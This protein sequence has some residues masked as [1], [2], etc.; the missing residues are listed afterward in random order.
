MPMQSR[1]ILPPCERPAVGVVGT[2]QKFAVRR[3]YCVGQNYAEHSRE[4]G[5]DPDKE[6]P[7][8]FS[9]PADAIVADGGDVPFPSQ[10]RDLHHEIELVVAIAKGGRDIAIEAAADHI[11]GYAVGIDL[12]RRDIQAEAKKKGRPWDMAK[13]FDAS[14]PI[15]PIAPVQVMG[16]PQQGRIW[17]SV[18]DYVQQD[19]DLNQM[20]WSPGHIISILSRYVALCPGDLVFTGTP[21]GVGPLERGDRVTAGIEG[22]GELEIRII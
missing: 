9:K 5:G 1:F 18:N 19:G 7:F 14:A 11:F 13:G 21:A 6:E 2:D 16:H 22:T 15:G 10:T 20:I 17:L 3:I 12:T 8:F 4:M